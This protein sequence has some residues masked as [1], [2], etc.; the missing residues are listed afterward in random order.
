M[1]IRYIY[2][3]CVLQGE[4]FDPQPLL[5]LDSFKVV[6]YHCIGDWTRVGRLRG[7]PETTGYIRLGA[8]GVDFD[9]FIDPV[10]AK[11]I[12]EQFVDNLLSIKDLIINSNACLK[13]LYLFLGY[14]NQGYWEF[15]PQLLRKIREL[16]LTLAPSFSEVDDTFFGSPAK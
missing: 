4:R 7:K 5:N 13:V 15:S 16:N 9:K 11:E 6:N 1:T 10:L 3:R 14:E 8:K 12:L 2:P